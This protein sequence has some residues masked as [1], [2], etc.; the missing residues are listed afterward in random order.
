[1][2]TNFTNFLL[3]IGEN[4][5]QLEAFKQ[6]PDAV[7]DA[8]GLTPAEKTLLL[9]GNIQLI[10]S[11]LLSDPG[12]KEAMGIPPV[13]ILPARIPMLIFGSDLGG[14]GTVSMLAGN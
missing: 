4:P 1:M 14:G 13:Q 7:M 2:A 11:T 8:A 3:S 6:N 12:L 9:S 10:R 5:Q